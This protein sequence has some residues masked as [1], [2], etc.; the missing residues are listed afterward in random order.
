MAFFHDNFHGTFVANKILQNCILLPI[1]QLIGLP[2]V[3]SLITMVRTT[4][5]IYDRYESFSTISIPIGRRGLSF[6]KNQVFR[7]SGIFF[8]TVALQTG[9]KKKKKGNNKCSTPSRPLQEEEKKVLKKSPLNERWKLSPSEFRRPPWSPSPPILD[10][11][12]PR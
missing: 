12:G 11:L 8:Y 9:P 1:A 7:K 6:I 5:A 10:I 3:F 4:T 2:I